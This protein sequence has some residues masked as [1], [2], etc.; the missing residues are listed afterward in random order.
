MNT[1]ESLLYTIFVLTWKKYPTNSAFFNPTVTFLLFSSIL[2]A[3]NPENIDY[4]FNGL[5]SC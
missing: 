5:P 2:C 1:I 4:F 3:L